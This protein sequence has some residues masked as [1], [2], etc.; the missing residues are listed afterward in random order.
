[1]NEAEQ[2]AF[3]EAYASC[4]ASAPKSYVKEF[5]QRHNRGEDIPWDEHYTSVMDA[6]CLW[7]EAR[8]YFKEEANAS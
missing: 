1:M 6:Y 3:V 7:N 2:D 8:N 5:V 4:V